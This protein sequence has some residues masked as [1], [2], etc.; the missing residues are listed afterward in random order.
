M[1]DRI[2]FLEAPAISSKAITK[3]D[4]RKASTDE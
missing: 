3:L 2:S 1:V 4:S